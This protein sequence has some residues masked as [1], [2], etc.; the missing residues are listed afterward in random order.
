MK[1]IRIL[2]MIF[3]LAVTFTTCKENENKEDIKTRP[4]TEYQVKAING[5]AIISYTMPNDENILYVMAEY[6]RNGKIYTE[7]SSLYNNSLKIEG[8]N[9]MNLVHA[10]LYTV[11]YYETKSDP[12]PVEF[13][14]LE[15]PI[16]IAYHSLATKPGFGGIHLNWKN[17]SRTEFGIRLMVEE[18][19]D[20]IDKEMYFSAMAEGR[21]FRTYKAVPT[22][23][24]ISFEDKWGNISDTAKV[25][26]TPI[27]E[28][29]IFP[30]VHK[31]DV[32]YDKTD[33]VSPY[34]RACLYDHKAGNNSWFAQKSETEKSSVFTLDMKKEYLLSRVKF[35][36]RQLAADGAT[37][38][39]PYTS[40][41]VPLVLEFYGCRDIS[42]DQLNDKG[43]W[44]HPELEN[45][46]THDGV[47]RSSPSF[48]DEWIFLGR[49]TRTRLDE[50]GY[51]N[52]EIYRIT[53]QG[54][55]FL[56]P[57][58]PQPIRYIRVAVMSVFDSTPP[59][60]AIFQIGELNFWG[61]DDISQSKI[62]DNETANK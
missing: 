23:F 33:D 4:I 35:W 43:Y 32:P 31:M 58:D 19:G 39:S 5:G 20:L 44:L 40:G 2:W 57:D 9:T 47:K 48:T 49:F 50:L 10:T 17:D 7:R 11:N 36:A 18:K 52:E 61:N 16:S 37:R 60:G 29:E 3:L 25:T 56:F 26:L 28:D 13:T 51:T 38:L 6:E 12:L 42:V 46:F 21:T 8:F 45:D 27:P 55:E 34:T 59:T 54:E 30:Y 1:H 15:S 41:K 53:D 62:P 24:A 14:P 22:T